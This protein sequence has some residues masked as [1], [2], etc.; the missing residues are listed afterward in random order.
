MGD[1][2][3]LKK[4]LGLSDNPFDPL[5]PGLN[6]RIAGDAM[7]V[8]QYPNLVER[9]FC[10]EVAG[11]REAE[12]K[13][14]S[15]LFGRRKDDDGSQ[16]RSAILIVQ[17]VRGSGRTTL[18][19]LIR[20]WL[21]RRRTE[22]ADLWESCDLL[23]DCYTP[24]PATDDVR[25]KFSELQ[26]ALGKMIQNGSKQVVVVIDN[27]PCG[28]FNNVVSVYKSADRLNRVFVVTTDDLDLIES[29]LDAYEPVIE[30][31][32]LTKLTAKDVRAFINKRVG[33][34]RC[35][36][37]KLPQS[38]EFNLFP[39]AST[40]PD[41][42]VGNGSKPMRNVQQWLRRQIEERHDLLAGQGDA[43]DVA[44]LAAEALL[45][46]MIP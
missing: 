44:D 38:E 34:Y 35:N 32:T 17:G 15:A 40:A 22:N 5:M 6:K 39:F 18:A 41:R 42:A 33:D 1:D 43:L 19:N 20:G 2:F 21:L 46:R 31:V 26:S 4:S 30:P 45:Q 16:V 37:V 8:D 36:Q 28:Y 24:P 13:L 25:S 29:D 12:Q 14:R 3:G 27:L 9:M 23:F 7:P 10:A 11:V